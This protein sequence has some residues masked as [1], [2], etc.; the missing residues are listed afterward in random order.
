MKIKNRSSKR[1]NKL[2]GIQ[3]GRIRTVTFSFES[4]GDLDAYDLRTG[5]RL[6]E[7]QA[8]AEEATNHRASSKAIRCLAP[9]EIKLS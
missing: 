5:T 2:D 9:L 7:S 4:G 1:N 8:A 6:L 3:V